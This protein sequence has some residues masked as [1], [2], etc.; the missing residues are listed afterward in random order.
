MRNW[1]IGWYIREYEQKGADRASLRNNLMTAL[2]GVILIPM[3]RRG[4][5][6]GKRPRRRWPEVS[7]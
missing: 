2:S 1:L 3:R 7:G 5:K 4:A 6:Y